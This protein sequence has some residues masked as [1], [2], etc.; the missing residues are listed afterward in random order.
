MKRLFF[1]VFLLIVLVSCK[2]GVPNIEVNNTSNSINNSTSSFIQNVEIN[3]EFTFQII[4]D[5]H[6]SINGVN[7]SYVNMTKNDNGL[8]IT[9]LDKAEIYLS[10]VYVNISV[11][12]LELYSETDSEKMV[13]CTI[14]DGISS[15]FATTNS[16]SKKASTTIL[17]LKVNEL[18]ESNWTIRLSTS[19][20]FV[21]LKRLELA[22]E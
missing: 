19:S 13:G 14:S 17:K 3:T 1:M 22:I 5:S 11:V 9:A 6:Y 12:Y 4:A 7:L 15:C 20:D 21:T 18:E 10:N 16:L 2:E 8:G